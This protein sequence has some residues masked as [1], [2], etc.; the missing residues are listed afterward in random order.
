MALA[1]VI[2]TIALLYGLGVLVAASTTRTDGATSGQTRVDPLFGHVVDVVAHRSAQVRCWSTEGW[3]KNAAEWHRRWPQLGPLG[4]WRAYTTP[5][6]PPTVNLPPYVCNALTRL[7]HEDVPVEK[8]RFAA[9]LS[10]SAGMLA[11]ES[12]HV[13]GVTDEA[14]AECYGMQLIRLTA[15][16]FGR[17]SAEGEYLARLYWRRW[18]PRDNSIYGSRDCRNRGRLDLRPRIDVWP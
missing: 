1:G 3:T 7:A 9:T 18:Y 6:Y 17:K 14:E 16:A 2:W 12:Q 15:V 4:P 13:H 5:D 11:H 8:D 10:W